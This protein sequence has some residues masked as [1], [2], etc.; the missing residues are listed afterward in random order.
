MS[1]HQDWPLRRVTG[2]LGIL[3]F[4]G[5]AITF[6]LFAPV[7]PDP[8]APISELR[9]FFADDDAV[10][11]TSNWIFLVSLVFLFLPFAAGLRS[12]LAENDVDSGMWTRT[13][14]G[15]AVGVVAI[16][17]VGS[18]FIGSM[19]LAFEPGS[20]DDSVLRL[21][22]YADAYIFS[23]PLTIGVALFLAANSIVVLR[24]GAL[25]T[26]LGWLGLVIALLGLI[27]AWWP[28]DGDPGGVLA[29]LALTTFPLLGIW[30]LLVGINLLRTPAAASETTAA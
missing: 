18:S 16:G 20:F 23:V 27:G 26:W 9:E 15:I 22:A 3:F 30:S 28:L 14:F 17:G 29:A 1:S 24:T 8:D 25:W 4:V 11:H 6:A 10:I 19:M 2:I 5:L 12:V 7:Q 13:A 21:I